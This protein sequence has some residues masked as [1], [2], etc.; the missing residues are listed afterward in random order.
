MTIFTVRQILLLH[1]RMIQQFGGSSG[2]RDI[3]MLESAIARPFA[4][5]G[6][7][8]LYQTFFMK[9]GAFIQSIV[10]NHPF[11]DG[12][13]R[14]AF[15]GAVILLQANDF[16]IEISDE[17]SVSFMISVANKNLSVD[18]IAAWLKKHA[19][20]GNFSTRS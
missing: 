7:D 6:G 3:G 16:L 5:F 13:K 14:T 15:A 11:L 17:E 9:V 8:D 2:V 10:K 19:K 4:T 20:K 1:E 12:N 18:E